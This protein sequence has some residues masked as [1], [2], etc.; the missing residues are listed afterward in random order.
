MKLLLTDGLDTIV[1][2]ERVP[3]FGDKEEVGAFDDA[4]FDGAGDAL[5]RLLFVAV[6]CE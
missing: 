6:V 4:F 2:V 1:V 3:E 5:A